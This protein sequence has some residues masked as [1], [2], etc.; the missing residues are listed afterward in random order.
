MAK[1]T[2]IVPEPKLKL[3]H[4]LLQQG[5]SVTTTVGETVRGFLL[6]RLGLKAKDIEEKIQT[7]F[8]NGKAV[9]NVDDARIRNGATLA[10]SGALPGLVGATMRRGG[11]YA[12]FRNPIQYR[13][14]EENRKLQE[15][16]IQL[17][18]FNILLGD[19]GPGLLVNGIGI[20]SSHLSDFLQRNESALADECTIRLEE[21]RE[22]PCRDLSVQ[23]SN[24]PDDVIF[25]KVITSGSAFQINKR[26]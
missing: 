9:D 16:T 15:G 11:F 18:L 20:Q 10:L 26:P 17:K 1:L 4:F 7:V 22:I 8:L 12:S 13:E 24:G 6:N 14:E 21:G 3:F 25:I 2:F 19:L 23:P 5:V